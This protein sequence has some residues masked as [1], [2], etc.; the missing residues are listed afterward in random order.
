MKGRRQLAGKNWAGGTD[1]L[2]RVRR[3]RGRE[4]GLETIS[5]CALGMRRGLL[6]QIGQSSPRCLR[7]PLEWWEGA[8]S[9]QASSSMTWH[10][11]PGPPWRGLSHSRWRREPPRAPVA[12]AI[13]TLVRSINTAPVRQPGDVRA[14]FHVW[15]EWLDRLL[16][17][18][19]FG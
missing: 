5:Q 10:Q 4:R 19:S 14:I 6:C 16:T 7:P 1:L 11:T 15:P 2:W 17:T 8:S 12:R 18:F 3:C 9:Q 13:Q